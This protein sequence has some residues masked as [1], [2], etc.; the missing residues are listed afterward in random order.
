MPDDSTGNDYLATDKK[1]KKGQNAFLFNHGPAI[2][3]ELRSHPERSTAFMAEL[4]R[5]LI[6]SGGSLS[7][8]C[9]GIEPLQN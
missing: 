8:R 4:L 2:I 9:R 7:G 3:A 5:T 1:T 6:R